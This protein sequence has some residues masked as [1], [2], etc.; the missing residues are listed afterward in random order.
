MITLGIRDLIVSFSPS[1]DFLAIASADGRL[2]VWDAL[3]GQ[4]QTEFSDFRPKSDGSEILFESKKGHLAL[5]FKCMKWV[6]LESKKKKMHVNS[7]LVLGTDSGDVL[8]V[9]VSTGQLRWRV[10]DC[11]SGGVSAISFSSHNSFLYTAGLD[12]MVCQIDCSIGSVIRKFRL[13][14]KGISTMA[15]SADGN[16]LAA[17]AGLLKIFSCTDNE[18]IQKFSGHPVSVRCMIFSE[19]GKYILTSGVGE[20][21]IAIWKID[22]GKKKSASCVLSMDHPA[23]FLDSR[24][25][26][27][28]GSMVQDLY[29]LAL[30]EIGI[31]YFWYGSSIEELQNA[32]PT[33]ISL[34]IESSLVKRNNSQAVF[35]AKLDG[36]VRSATVS[37]HVAYGSLIKPSF[38]KLTVENGVDMSLNMSK[39]G[40]L[41]P[42]SQSYISKKGQVVN[43]AVTTLDRA[44]AEDAILPIAKLHVNEKK[45]KYSTPYPAVD[46]EKA[47]FDLDTNKRKS[48]SSPNKV[49]MQRT[50]V[51][52]P[53][54][55]EDR[56]RAAGLIDGEEKL[57]GKDFSN[58]FH[59]V[60]MYEK[61]DVTID[62]NL[63]RRKMTRFKSA[64]IHPLLKLSGRLQL[65]M[66]QID[67]AWTSLPAMQLVEK[68]VD[69]NEDGEDDEDDDGDIDEVIY[70]EDSESGCDD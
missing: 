56:L 52:E 62:G 55:I 28:E 67:K 27:K 37:V 60:T 22:G 38:E 69:V 26:D 1:S 3:K 53:M 24:G 63:P 57:E 29:V 47:K 34:L 6:Q 44:N 46:F 16:M 19:D 42:I 8:A 43:A 49:P 14:T 4:L 31:C 33:K 30:S 11:H 59:D 35:A 2:K 65:I 12:G 58:G 5:N 66:A 70:D 45:R 15:I 41:F 7:L 51:D 17:A 50:E 40:V 68:F 48:S 20:R 64:A 54:C 10:C 9:E 39:E 25:S 61:L 18:K 32:R 13:F 21:H 23:V 36:I